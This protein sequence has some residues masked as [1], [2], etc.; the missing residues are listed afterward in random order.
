MR[1]ES[2]RGESEDREQGN[3]VEDERARERREDEQQ[4]QDESVRQRGTGEDEE[5]MEERARPAQP[6]STSPLISSLVGRGSG[7]RGTGD[8]LEIGALW[9]VRANSAAEFERYYSQLKAYYFDYRYA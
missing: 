7:A 5:R 3:D 6:F 9:S 4:E 8:A 2:T 1:G